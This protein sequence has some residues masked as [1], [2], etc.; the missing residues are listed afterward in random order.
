MNAHGFP[1]DVTILINSLGIGEDNPI[2]AENLETAL[3]EGEVNVH[4]GGTNQDETRDF[5]RQAIID[6][7]LPIH[8]TRRGY[9]IIDSEPQFQATIAGME[10]RI[11]AYNARIQAVEEGWERRK[12]DPTFPK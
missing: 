1:N 5:V 8:S 11:D 7:K 12:M 10:S 6:H 4:R 2:S 3:I 9:F